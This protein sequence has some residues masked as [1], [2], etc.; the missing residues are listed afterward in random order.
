MASKN[1]TLSK[2][3]IERKKGVVV[4]PLAEYERMREDLEMLRSKRLE[5][6]IEK[7]RQEVKEGK[8]FTLKEVKEKLNL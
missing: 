6:D 1:I 8:T 5:R 3:I 2:D 7:A 4:L